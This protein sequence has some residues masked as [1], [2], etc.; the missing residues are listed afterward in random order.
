MLR[1]EIII[2][3]YNFLTFLFL[4]LIAMFYLKGIFSKKEPA[5]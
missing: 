5:C 3:T 4:Y 1:T 2:D